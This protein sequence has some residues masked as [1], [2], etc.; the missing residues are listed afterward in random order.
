M[1]PNFVRVV[2]SLPEPDGDQ[3]ARPSA[4]AE[5]LDMKLKTVR[6]HLRNAVK[7]GHVESAK[8]NEGLVIYRQAAG[9][10]APAATTEEPDAIPPTPVADV[11]D[12]EPVAVTSTGVEYVPD[13]EPTGDGGINRE[14]IT[15]TRVDSLADSG[16]TTIEGPTVTGDPVGPAQTA[17]EPSDP[18][19]PTEVPE[20]GGSAGSDELSAVLG[21]LESERPGVVAALAAPPAPAPAR[22]PVR[23]TCTH[24]G[25]NRP[26]TR[27]GRSWKHDDPAVD[28]N[29]KPTTRDPRRRLDVQHAT[30][31]ALPDGEH[32]CG[33]AITK[34]GRAW[35]HDDGSTD[36]KP[37]S[38][39]QPE[40][41][42]TQNRLFTPGKLKDAATAFLQD[43]YRA[44]PERSYSV[45]EIADG[46]G[47]TVSSA[48]YAL[49]LL[50]SDGVIRVTGVQPYTYRAE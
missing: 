9:W 16:V 5:A 40:R 34:D 47:A 31:T 28:A 8:D 46:T 22:A 50:V 14:S 6:D 27:D 7:A 42:G 35:T 26:V 48:G 15:A 43:A 39:K 32:S 38:R 11:P 4:V 1:N 30:C 17:V 19:T 21:V 45:K 29:H 37:T 44:D 23:G 41:T 36:H 25:C 3:W 33:K 10:S 24:K 2:D 18:P 12:D 20:N 13:D 49:N